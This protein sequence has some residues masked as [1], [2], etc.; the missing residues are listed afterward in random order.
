M[1]RYIRQFIPKGTDFNN[2][3][4][5][6]FKKLQIDLN[7]RPQKCLNYLTPNEVYFGIKIN[8]ENTI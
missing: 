7:N 3:S 8:I 6:Y 4:Y 1:N 5:Q 2:I